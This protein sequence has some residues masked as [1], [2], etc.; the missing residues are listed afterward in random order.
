MRRSI[1]IVGAEAAEVDDLLDAGACSFTC[2]GLGRGAVL[3]LEVARAE[4]MNEVVRDVRSLEC[5][6]DAVA[7]CGAA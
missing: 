2:N 3:L 1:G 6:A 4:R 7:R 5:S